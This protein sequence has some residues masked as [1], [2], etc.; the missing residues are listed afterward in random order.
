M[1]KESNMV[2]LT[3]TIE[4]AIEY[5]VFNLEQ[6]IRDIERHASS[7]RH[8]LNDINNVW[9]LDS[10]QI[11]VRN[12]RDKASNIRMLLNKFETM[13]KELQVFLK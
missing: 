10:R 13:S 3:V 9:S 12:T 4:E 8:Q 11:Y 1:S 5:Y 6:I 2:T 7:M